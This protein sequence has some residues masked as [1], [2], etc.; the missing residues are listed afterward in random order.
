MQSASFMEIWDSL[1]RMQIVQQIAHAL[2]P[3]RTK[4]DYKTAI[5][6]NSVTTFVRLRKITKQQM[7]H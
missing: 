5:F 4:G 7:A 1:W 3:L 6:S 2:Q